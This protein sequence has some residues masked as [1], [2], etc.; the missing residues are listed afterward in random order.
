VGGGFTNFIRIKL[1]VPYR[2]GL[3]ATVENRG[4]RDSAKEGK[5]HGVTTAENRDS[6]SKFGVFLLLTA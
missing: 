1:C 6:L 3:V 2:V 4:W 5:G